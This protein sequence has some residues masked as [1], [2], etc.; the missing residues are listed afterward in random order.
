MIDGVKIS[1]LDAN[2][3]Q[4]ES[5]L[6]F[7]RQISEDTGL[8]KNYKVAEYHFCKIRIYDSGTVLFIGS[9]HKLWNSLHNVLAPNYK[10]T[11]NYKG[12]NGN[13]FTLKDIIEVRH[14]L[15]K[16]FEC[17]SD[18][19]IF[20]NIEFGINTTPNFNPQLFIIGLLYLT[21]KSFEFRFDNNFAQVIYQRYRVKIYNKSNQ[22]GI[23]EKTL[24][25]E[26]Q[27]KK[28]EE[29]KYKKLDI[30]NINSFADINVSTLNNAKGLLLRHFNRVIYF[31][32]TIR[33]NEFTKTI[34]T[35]LLKYK[36]PQYW[37]QFKTKSNKRDHKKKL[38]KY[39]SNHSDNLKE[40]IISNILKKFELIIAERPQIKNK[41]TAPF[42]Q[43]F[44][45]KKTALSNHSS[46]GLKGANKPYKKCRVT[47]V[48]IS[49]QKEDSILLS[50]TGLR[51]YFE[52]DK[53]I[54][55]IIKNK[56]LSKKW[57]YNGFETQI[58]E[59]A[60]N[61]RNKHSNCKR[62]QDD[63]NNPSQTRLF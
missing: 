22:Y 28:S 4:L 52:N 26:T 18:K 59:L 42:N 27:I 30:I 31:D 32:Y 36:N 33:E 61:I 23:I 14:H 13:L 15:K 55:L 40:Q 2:I 44:N 56:Y 20:Q 5:K 50:H 51:Y 16:L 25:I 11:K 57:L 62:S 35:T 1:V 7:Y 24:R 46:K 49:M 17:T 19:M 47:A 10:K 3:N 54:F 63:N 9:I 21:T 58:K 8:Y 45:T 41:K 12:Y 60:H 29:Y 34:K 53:L 37:F 48:D 6:I 43:L 38:Q 39:I